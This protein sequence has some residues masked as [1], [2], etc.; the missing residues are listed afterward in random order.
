MHRGFIQLLV[1]SYIFS[2]CSPAAGV[3]ALTWVMSPLRYCP[4]H[5][6]DSP[7]SASPVCCQGGENKVPSKSSSA[8]EMPERPELNAGVTWQRFGKTR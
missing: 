1:P 6:A 4:K 7:K 8:E 5:R 3:P 2:I